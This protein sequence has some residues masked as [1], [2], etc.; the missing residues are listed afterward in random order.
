[1]PADDSEH[2]PPDNL[3]ILAAEDEDVE[4]YNIGGFHPTVIGYTF[5]DGRYEMVHKFGFGSCSNRLAS[6][7]Q[8]DAALRLP[9]DIGG[10]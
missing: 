9:Q 7:R 1:M 10:G 4:G 2:R 6:R 3:Y 5:H 8:T